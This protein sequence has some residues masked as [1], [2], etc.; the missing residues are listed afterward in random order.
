VGKEEVSF[1]VSVVEGEHEHTLSKIKYRPAP[2][3]S[4][5]VRIE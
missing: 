1:F 5:M 2:R 4:L 3:S